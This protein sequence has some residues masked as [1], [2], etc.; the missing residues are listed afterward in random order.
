MDLRQNKALGEYLDHLL[1][2]SLLTHPL[3][4]SIY[5]GDEFAN[6]FGSKFGFVGDPGPT[7]S[8]DFVSHHSQLLP[9]QYI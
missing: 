6:I 3:L 1:R 9:P 2:Y 4:Y 8:T 7:G 5:Q